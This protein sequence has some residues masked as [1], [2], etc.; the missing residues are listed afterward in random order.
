MGGAVS[1]ESRLDCIRQSRT[2]SDKLQSSGI[3]TLTIDK[4]GK[5]LLTLVLVGSFV[6]REEETQTKKEEPEFDGDEMSYT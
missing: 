5:Y 1:S 6:V 4:A 2:L 3:I